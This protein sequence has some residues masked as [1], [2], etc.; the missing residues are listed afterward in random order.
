MFGHG[1]MA[2]NHAQKNHADNDQ[3]AVLCLKSERAVSSRK[4]LPAF[5]ILS[6]NL[7]ENR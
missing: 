2:D 7:H 3:I 4:T 5:D 1:G 6:G